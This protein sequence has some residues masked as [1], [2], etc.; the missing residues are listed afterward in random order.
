[1]LCCAIWCYVKL[2]IVSWVRDKKKLHMVAQSKGMCKFLEVCQQTNILNLPYLPHHQ[3]RQKPC[4]WLC[5]T[6]THK[7]GGGGVKLQAGPK[8][9]KQKGRL[10]CRCVGKVGRWMTWSV[11]TRKG[12]RGV[13]LKKRGGALSRNLKMS[14]Q[15]LEGWPWRRTTKRTSQILTKTEVTRRF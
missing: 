15:V 11:A 7:L 4:R 2:L 3:I 10:T 12:E 14:A 9:P 6:A 8:F 1:M 13:C 5:E